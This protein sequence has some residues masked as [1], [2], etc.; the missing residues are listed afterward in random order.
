M[1]I[2]NSNSN[3]GARALIASG[4]RDTA[5]SQDDA[6]Y[7]THVIPPKAVS[8]TE[9]SIEFGA[10]DVLKT[11]PSDVSAIGVGSTGHLYLLNETNDAVPPENVL[12]GY[13]FGARSGETLRVLVSSA[14]SVT[15]YSAR[16]TMP[17]GGD[18][19]ADPQIS[20]QKTYTVDRNVAG[21]NSIGSFS[22][23]GVSNVITFTE[24]HSFIQGESV[25]I[26]SSTGQLPD[27]LEPNSIYY[28]ITSGLTTNRNIK[29]AKTLNDALNSNPLSIN[30]KGGV[31]KVVSRVSDK[32]SGEIGH[33]IQYDSDN[34]QWYVKVATAA[35][36]NTL[37]PIVVGL[38]STSLGTATP[39]TFIKRRSDTRNSEDTLYRYR[40]VIPANTGGVVARP[41]TEGF[42]L[43]ESNTSIGSTDAEIQT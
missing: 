40:Y 21:I 29:L 4:F 33:P 8:L 9:T 1:S 14:G 15:E 17:A 22:A 34:S 26:I 28:A 42:I 6:G 20:G 39:R 11:L 38:G 25:R 24:A 16:V 37:Y 30:E 31:L 32:N 18:D 23:G 35:T 27:G 2:T 13:R 19:I 12:E 36:E 41:P 7:I 10:I 5:F 3:F 43:Q